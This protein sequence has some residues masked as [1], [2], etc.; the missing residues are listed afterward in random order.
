MKLHAPH[1]LQGGRTHH[2]AVCMR[3]SPLLSV[4]NT[5]AVLTFIPSPPKYTADRRKITE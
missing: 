4:P 1:L 5:E 2:E 3:R